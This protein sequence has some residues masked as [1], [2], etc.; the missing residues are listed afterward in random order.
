[1][2]YDFA[3]LKRKVMSRI[4]A[5]YV[6]R[7]LSRPLC[8]KTALFFALYAWIAAAVSVKDVM[9][10]MPSMAELSALISFS[11]SAFLNAGHFLQTLSVAA[12]VI[13]GWLLFD[14]GRNALKG[15]AYLAEAVR[16]R[17]RA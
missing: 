3:N 9:L 17:V 16:M 11:L 10:N 12:V 1:M 6:W 15:M 7:I 8:V 14:I 2:N 13:G 5:I 4:Y